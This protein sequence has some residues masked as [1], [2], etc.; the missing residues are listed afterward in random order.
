MKVNK[1]DHICIAVKNLEE[2]KKRWEPLLGKNKP[3]DEYIDEP[4]KINVARY[5]L[6]EVGFELME[7]TAPDG[8]VAKFIEKRGEGIMLVSFNVD[9]TREA[10][11]ELEKKD[12][13]F[14]G[15]ARTFR[16]CEFA[17]IHPK[18]VNGVL[19]EIIDDK[20]EAPK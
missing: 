5:Y 12:Y 20:T 19:L 15:G 3:D 10:M 7:S 11:A 13:P 1:I 16:E 2:A 9:N 8:D 18:A 17:F 6:G 4:E 14:I